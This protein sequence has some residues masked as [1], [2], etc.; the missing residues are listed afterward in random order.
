MTIHPDLAAEQAYIDR[1]YECLE[2]A[3]SSA[4]RLKGMVEVGAGGTEQ[5]RFEREVIYDTVAYRLSQLHLGDAALCFGRIDRDPAEGGET[6]YIGRLA[7]SDQEQEPLVVDWRAPV[8]EPFYRATGRENMGLAR[9]RHFATRGRQ[10]LGIED[11]LFG[12]H[13]L[14]LG[15]GAGLQGQGALIAALETARSGRLGDIVAT[16]Q[17]EQDEIIRGP[18]PGVLV[19]QGGPGTGKTVVALHRAAYLL[20]T[21]RFPLE[22]QGVLVVGPN[23]LFLAYIEQVLPSLGEAGVELAVLADLIDHV[24]VKGRDRSEA[25]RLKGDDVM[26]KVLAK[27][28]RDRKRPLRSTLRVGHGLQTLTLTVDDSEWIVHEARRR[29]RTHNAG[30][31][32]VEREVARVLA[33]SSRTPLEPGELWRQI[34]RHPDVFAAMEWMWPVLTPAQLLHD[35]YGSKSL[36]HL[37][38]DRLL[39][40][41]TVELL[42]RP[43]SE[44]VDDVVWTQD[45]VPLLDE[46]RALLGPRPRKK[47]N[48]DADDDVR[49]YGHI[50][51][52]EAQDLSPMQLRMLNRRSLNGSMTVVGD[53]AQSTG[54]WAHADWKEILSLLPSKREARREEL[55]VG[56][57]IP[58]PNMELAARVLAHAAPDI[59][60]PRSVRQGGR[61]PRLNRVEPSSPIGPA[62]L[63]AVRAELAAVGTGNVAVICPASRV[64]ECSRALAS[65]GVEHG[66]ATERGLS[67]QVTVVPVG[68][69][70]GLELDATVVVDPAG[71]I[72]EEAQGMRALYVALTRATKHLTVVHHGDLPEAMEPEAQRRLSDRW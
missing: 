1:A 18:L 48:D 32:F 14:D 46:A 69:V 16:I 61:P 7:V 13:A 64:E 17:G 20:Y 53:I 57:R 24:S 36:L 50:V 40:D 33:E 68:I 45:D 60:S 11:E 65:G 38:G 35:L 8:A 52:D 19:V 72:D 56:Y 71:I 31:R 26:A 34:R 47:R 29:Y 43:R 28:V 5:A 70:K 51:V 58:E 37:A 63:D 21:H 4:N 2:E 30:R 3:R 55:T 25:A 54:A 39:G 10:L 12:E 41:G 9:R 66:V 67:H 27:A 15:E 22:D 42:H 23:R 49:T 44:S 62:V 6:Y 59:T